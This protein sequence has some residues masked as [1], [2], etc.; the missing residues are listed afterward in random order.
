FW[1]DF[2][3]Q[4]GYGANR[5]LGQP[6]D[7]VPSL[8]LTN[9]LQGFGLVPLALALLGLCTIW[10]AGRAEAAV[11]CTFPVAY[12]LFLLPKSVFFA[13][14]VVPL[15]PFASLL[16]GYAVAL[17]VGW[18]RPAW[19]PAGLVLLASAALAQPL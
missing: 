16:A 2:V 5:W 7:P 15:L 14:L 13:R 3:T 6:P 1:A 12:L 17:V 4:S 8:Y 9:L 18:L 10:R 11:L 19:R